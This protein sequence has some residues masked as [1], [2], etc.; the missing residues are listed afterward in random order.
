MLS[1]LDYGNSL[2]YGA[3]RSDLDK[4]QKTMYSAARLITG[5]KKYEHISDALRNLHL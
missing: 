1:R 4:L 3:I 2:L 5:I